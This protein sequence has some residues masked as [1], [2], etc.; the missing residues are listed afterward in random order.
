MLKLFQKLGWG[1]MKESNGGSE[2]KY[3]IFSHCQNI[4]K[5]Y[6]VPRPNKTIFKKA[7][8][9]DLKITLDK[10]LLCVFHSLFLF[11][12]AFITVAIPPLL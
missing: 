1:E 7:E 12:M 11:S 4:C 2:F 9:K 8:K 3:D 5:C 10:S 6:S